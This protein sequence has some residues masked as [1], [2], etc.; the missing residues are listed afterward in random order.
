MAEAGP[1]VP[2]IPAPPAS[3]AQQQSAQQVQHMPH[4]NWSHFKQEFS[5]KPEDS[6]AHLLRTNDWINTH[7]FQ[8][9]IKIQR[10][11]N[12]SRSQIVV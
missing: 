6:E 9:G 10:F 12:I 2:D 1:Q 3:Q 8:E 11:S 5:G 4:L 7:N